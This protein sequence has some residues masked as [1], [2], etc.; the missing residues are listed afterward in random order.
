MFVVRDMPPLLSP[1][2]TTITITVDF[3]NP[4]PEMLQTAI[5]IQ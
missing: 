1:S 5:A 2:T 3:N 4:N